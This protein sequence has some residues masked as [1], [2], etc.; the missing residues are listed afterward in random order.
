M[1]NNKVRYMT[2]V[3]MLSAVAYIFALVGSL[4]P[5]QFNSF[6]RYDPKDAI[7]VIAGFALGPMASLLVSVLVAFLELITISTTGLIGF[8]MNIISSAAFSCIAALVY[9][10]LRTLNGAIYGLALSSAVTVGLMIVWNYLVTP[11]YMGV[12]RQVVAEMLVPVFLP[13][14]LIKC[15]LNAGLTMLLYKPS[16]QAM[17]RVGLISAR[18]ENSSKKLKSGLYIV[19]PTLIFIAFMIV[20]F[21]IFKPNS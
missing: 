18:V 4:V 19:L 9:K 17:R 10:R 11:V 12:P 1:R 16:V 5:I 2:N 6:L 8:A 7:I 15:G 21:I 3:G 14:N 13:F 20:L